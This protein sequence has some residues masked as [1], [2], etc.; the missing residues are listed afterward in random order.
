MNTGTALPRFTL[1]STNGQISFPPEGEWTVYVNATDAGTEPLATVTGEVSVETVSA[2]VLVKAPEVQETVP[3]TETES[4][5]GG[6]DGPTAIFVT[7][8]INSKAMML[9]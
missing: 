9:T 4:V 8:G 3:P 1:P 2:C 7:G 6:A 5:I